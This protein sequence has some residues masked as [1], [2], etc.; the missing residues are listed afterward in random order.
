MAGEKQ[1]SE[2]GTQAATE[3]SGAGYGNNAEVDDVGKPG[4]E[5]EQGGEAEQAAEAHPS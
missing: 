2:T 1:D 4:D 3:Q 5:T